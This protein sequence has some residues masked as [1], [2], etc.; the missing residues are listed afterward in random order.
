MDLHI[1]V[2]SIVE[3]IAQCH[4]SNVELTDI[5]V[6]KDAPPIEQAGSACSRLIALDLR[7]DCVVQWHIC[8]Q[9]FERLLKKL[10]IELCKALFGK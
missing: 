5:Q 2:C 6:E 8:N 1:D 10:R 4:K 9:V 3:Q 7:I